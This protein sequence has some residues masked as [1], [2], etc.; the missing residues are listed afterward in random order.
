[1]FLTVLEYIAVIVV[2]YFVGNISWARI[3]SKKKRGDI[4]KSGSGNPG[5]MNMLR[6][7]GAKIGFLTLLLDSLKGALPA[8]CGMLLFKYTGL[9]ANMGLYVAGLSAVLGHMWPVLYKFKGGKGVATAMGVFMVANPLWLLVAFVAGFIYVWLFDYGSVA[10]LFIIT[11]MCI[12][13][14]YKNGQQYVADKTTLLVLNL[15]LFAIFLL[16]WFAHR[17]NI[18]RLLLGKENKANL[19]KSFKKKLKIQKT[20]EAK[21]EYIEHKSQL[22]KEFKALKAEYRKDI[23]A[24]K[25]ELK[26]QYKKINKSLKQSNAELLTKEL[27]PAE[28]TMEDIDLGDGQN[29]QT[30]AEQAKNA[31]TTSQ[32]NLLQTD[33][34]NKKKSKSKNKHKT[35]HTKTA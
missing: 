16:I 25:K 7:Y 21:M 31:Q 35:K 17:Q 12:V 34:T 2:S 9:D 11:F 29:A 13:Q 15:L 3:I 22:K 6:T 28:Q 19:Q 8:L 26:K 1:M 24:K 20:E 23:K 18:V 30:K 5:S 14:G 27:K 33:G 32:A 10:S 4:T